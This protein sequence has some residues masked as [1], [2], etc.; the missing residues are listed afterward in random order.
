VLERVLPE[1]ADQLL[2]LAMQHAAAGPAA[3]F[4]A[5]QLMMIAATC[6][7]RSVTKLNVMLCSLV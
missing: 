5:A 6:V 2:G 4:A 3:R 7:V 1:S